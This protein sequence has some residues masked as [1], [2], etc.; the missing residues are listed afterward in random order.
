MPNVETTHFG[1]IEFE[2]ASVVVF[3]AGLPGFE[4][5]R[6]F[7]PLQF[8]DS[9]PL[10]FLQSVEV[11]ELCFVTLPMQAV[12]RKYRLQVGEED[13]ESIGLEASR[14]PTVG[15]ETL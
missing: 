10:V 14:Q 11:S 2:E 4:E 5:R 15:S 3:P 8:D 13:L 7:L 9:A 6:R 1:Q 12:D